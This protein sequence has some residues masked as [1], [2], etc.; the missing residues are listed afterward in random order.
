MAP[1]VLLPLPAASPTGTRCA[2]T[3]AFY[4]NRDGNEETELVK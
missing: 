1:L 3:L 2:V 4:K